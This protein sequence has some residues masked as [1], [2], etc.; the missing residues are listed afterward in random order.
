M[1][2]VGE[3]GDEA[4]VVEAVDEDH[5]AVLDEEVGQDD[6]GVLRTGGA[7]A[8]AAAC[9]GWIRLLGI[10]PVV[11]G[12]LLQKRGGG[13]G[14]TEVGV[15]GRQLMQN[16]DCEAV[17]DAA[18]FARRGVSPAAPRGNPHGTGGTLVVPDR[19]VQRP[20]IGAI[21]TD[22]GAP[23]VDL[24][25]T[26]IERF[27]IQPRLAGIDGHLPVNHNLVPLGAENVAGF[28]HQLARSRHG[29]HPGPT[30]HSPAM[31]QPV[32]TAQR[33]AEVFLIPGQIGGGHHLPGEIPNPFEGRGSD[34]SA[35]SRA[36]PRAV[37]AASAAVVV[38]SRH[39]V[40]PVKGGEG[41]GREKSNRKGG[42]SKWR[43]CRNAVMVRD[44]RSPRVGREKKAAFKLTASH[45]AA[46]GK[47]IR[48]PG[49]ICAVDVGLFIR[50][51]QA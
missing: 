42:R 33:I 19:E 35:A 46:G 51:L 36:V 6:P 8:A 10:A 20:A 16:L 50:P 38:M 29:P 49:K 39:G 48:F 40:D 37:P 13:R 25:G 23:R 27:A 5:L 44:V 1:V 14:G 7:G 32:V 47:R 3:G 45:A 2:E 28:D 43:P 9:G 11:S 18:V 17:F 31:Q 12:R 21:Y 41:M 34:P 4:A 24:G 30:D 26:G 15:A 22:I